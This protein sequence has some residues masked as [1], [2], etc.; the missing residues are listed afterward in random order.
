MRSFNSAFTRVSVPGFILLIA[1]LG[2]GCAGTRVQTVT[3]R[4]PDE[5]TTECQ[6]NAVAIA[7][8]CIR[9]GWEAGTSLVSCRYGRQVI[10]NG[11]RIAWVR[12]EQGDVRYIDA[13]QW[14]LYERKDLRG[15]MNEATVSALLADSGKTV[16]QE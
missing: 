16:V 11:H 4:F 5:L 12:D 14:G 3:R 10:D 7:K 6:Y 9:Q 15:R 13:N 2:T 8:W 1:M